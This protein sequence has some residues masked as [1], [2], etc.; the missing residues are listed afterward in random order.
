MIRTNNRFG[1]SAAVA[2]WVLVVSLLMLLLW[3]VLP[4]QAQS[5]TGGA[6]ITVNTTKDETT[7]NDGLCSL[8]EALQNANGDAQTSSDCKVGKG[9]DTITFQKGLSGTITL[10][11]A[12]GRSPSPMQMG[13]LSTAAKRASP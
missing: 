9:E 12:W 1:V 4:T 10:D 5:T 6:R 13:S 11:R 2:V 3:P 8:R 7:P